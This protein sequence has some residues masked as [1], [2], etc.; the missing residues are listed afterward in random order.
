M[1]SFVTP[2]TNDRLISVVPR[3]AIFTGG[4]TRSGGIASGGGNPG[5]LIQGFV[6]TGFTHGS[7]FPNA[8]IA[9]GSGWAIENNEI[10]YN[11]QV[12]VAL[13]DGIVLRGNFIHHN[14]RYGFTG[15]PLDS[16]LVENNEVSFN[17]TAQLRHR[18]G[19]PAAPRSS[20]ART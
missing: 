5:V 9:A 6:L 4:G 16:L 2:K 17:N 8:A 1:S 15:G 13:A 7:S 3:G 10:A 20:R 12:G 14:G 18:T 19:M 11:A